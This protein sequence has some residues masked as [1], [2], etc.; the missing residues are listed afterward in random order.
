MCVSSC[1]CEQVCREINKWVSER[2]REREKTFMMINIQGHI[3]P[4]IHYFLV[5]LLS[6]YSYTY[7]YIYIHGIHVFTYVYVYDTNTIY[8]YNI[9]ITYKQTYFIHKLQ[10]NAI[11]W[12]IETI[13]CSCCLDM[14]EGLSSS[15]LVSTTSTPI[16]TQLYKTF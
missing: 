16:V 14:T 1:I 5:P 10:N 13:F 8:I 9:K 3:S 15:Y 7:I 12:V 11:T 6:T 2:E 4:C